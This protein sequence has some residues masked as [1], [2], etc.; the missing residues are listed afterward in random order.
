MYGSL[1]TVAGV[2]LLP[3]T[4]NSKPLFITAVTLIA[5]GAV[6]MVISAVMARKSRSEAK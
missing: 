2:S 1:P 3:A 4:G 6:I 5:A